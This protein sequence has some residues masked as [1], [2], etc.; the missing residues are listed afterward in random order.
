[1]KGFLRWKGTDITGGP[2]STG[3]V[4]VCRCSRGDGTAGRSWRH[5]KVLVDTVENG[6]LFSLCQFDS[7]KE[8]AMTDKDIWAV[9]AGPFVV[10]GV[11]E[12]KPESPLLTLLAWMITVALVA[13]AISP[14]LGVVS[15]LV[16]AMILAA[17]TSATADPEKETQP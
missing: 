5:D 12:R 13:S 3:V 4:T 15:I 1:M 6:L 2:N 14:F 17:R 11:T 16:S 9:K 10:G 8:A 7:A